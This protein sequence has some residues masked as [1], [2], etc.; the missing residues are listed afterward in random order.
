MKKLFIIP[1][2]L[3]S[4]CYTLNK[5]Q[6]Q[7]IKAHVEYPQVT[8]KYCSEFYPTKDS[9]IIKKELAKGK[10]ITKIDS[11]WVNCDS[12]VKNNPGAILNVKVPCPP[13]KNSFRVDTIYDSKEIVRENTARVASL[14]F[15]LKKTEAIVMKLEGKVSFYKK[16]MWAFFGLIGLNVI[17]IV[18]KVKKII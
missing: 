14:Q 11:F 3:L 12:I 13:S 4:G 5:A 9:V 15:D 6:K 7:V 1:T 2:I 18:L 10:T 17:A 8:A 16:F